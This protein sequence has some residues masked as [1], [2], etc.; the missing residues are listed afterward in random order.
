MKSVS[1]VTGGTGG[2]GVAIA[3]RLA[4]ESTVIVTGRRKE[5]YEKV[6]GEFEGL[7]TI[8]MP[9]DC[10]NAEDMKTVAEKAKEIGVVKNVVHTAG[11]S[12][13]TGGKR[14]KP[15]D[16]V[17]NNVCSIINVL[18]AFIPVIGEGG[19]IVSISSMTSYVDI[20][21]KVYMDCFPDALEGN[22]TKMLEY[23]LDSNSTTYAIT[24]VFMRWLCNAN[25]GRVCERGARINTVSPG[26]I[27][28]PLTDVIE[29]DAPGSISGLSYVVPQGRLGNVDDVADAVEFLCGAKYVCG[30][31]I[32]VDG[33][34]Y[35]NGY[36]DQIED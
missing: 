33:G 11:I 17:K 25:I 13:F 15:I 2:M 10:T 22:Y 36:V 19:S 12:E 16:I 35:F 31:D 4:K 6:K 8:Y 20:D 7:D 14:N 24:K 28:S 21:Y 30:A 34:Y 1:V 5:T 18:D 23:G 9:A 3:K 29:K 32:L 27:E 26:F